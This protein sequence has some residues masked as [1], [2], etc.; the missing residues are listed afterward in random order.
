MPKTCKSEHS[1]PSRA[2]HS[3]PPVNGLTADWKHPTEIR[4]GVGRVA[5][6]P[7]AC[8][9]LDMR[10]PLVVTDPGLAKLPI[11]AKLIALLEEDGFQSVLFS[12]ISS[13]PD[14]ESIAEGARAFM[15][16]GYDGIIAL[17]GGSA[18]D[19]GKAMALTF[20]V[21]PK[22]I[23]EFVYRFDTPP[24]RVRKGLIPPII[25]IPTTAGTGSEVDASA[26][27]TDA[28]NKVKKSLYHPDLMPSIV[29]ADP[30]LTRRLIPYLTAATGVDALSHNLEA[31]CNP[32]FSP[33][34]DA[35]AL[36]GIRYAKE[37]LP[38]AF[39]QKRNLQARVY[40]M[41]A[42]IMGA[43]AFE[44]GLG[45]MHAMA[46]AVGAL[47]KTHHGRTVGAVMPY[48]LRFNRRRINGKMEEIARCL[49]LPRRD[50]RGVLDWLIGLRLELGMPAT[51]SDLGVRMEDIPKL[52]DRTLADANAPT[53]P[54][55]LD[56]KGVEQL[57][58]WS[59]RGK[60]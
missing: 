18:L 13:D 3:R 36:Q 56:P 16:G 24:P 55:K 38:V 19:A 45:A 54:V 37:W 27:I 46:H 51:L 5:E 26:V 17:G 57:F 52:V 9:S 60:L 49:D 1:L 12:R 23:W 39:H 7:D 15:E 42:S 8:R 47:F 41:A 10:H 2:N 21:G 28:A 6:V 40:T 29:I 4:F 32:A 59:I 35:I 31:F 33:M 44:K 22:K 53:N 48:V 34:L 58:R 11:A 43:I 14:S 25:A 20:A 50:Y 30:A